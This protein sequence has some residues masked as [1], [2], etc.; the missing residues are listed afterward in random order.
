MKLY[1]LYVTCEGCCEVLLCD[2]QSLPSGTSSLHI[3]PSL[4]HP[5]HCEPTQVPFSLALCQRPKHQSDPVT[6]APTPFAPVWPLTS[7]PTVPRSLWLFRHHRPTTPPTLTVNFSNVRKTLRRVYFVHVQ[8]IYCVDLVCWFLQ[9]CLMR[10]A[11]ISA[12]LSFPFISCLSAVLQCLENLFISV[13]LSHLSITSFQCVFICM[14]SNSSQSISIVRCVFFCRLCYLSPCAFSFALWETL[15][16]LCC[17]LE[18]L[19][20]W[21]VLTDNP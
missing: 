5:T 7:W 11:A 14:V 15:K 4:F 3:T 12:P 6:I 19:P 1:F 2:S 21:L 16:G 20:W 17:Q 8:C 10:P 9:Q 13:F 18:S